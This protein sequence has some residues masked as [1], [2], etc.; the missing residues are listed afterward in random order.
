[1]YYSKLVHLEKYKEGYVVD[2]KNPWLKDTLLGHFYIYPDSLELPENLENKT[3]IRTPVKSA[4]TYSST[5]W[6]VFLKLDEISRVK[7]ILESN[8]T[9][10]KTIKQLIADGKITDVGSEVNID[11]EK[12]FIYNQI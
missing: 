7:G 11:I 1:M 9:N 8:Y 10:N 12:S 2:I 6:S 5:Q 4:V 3:V